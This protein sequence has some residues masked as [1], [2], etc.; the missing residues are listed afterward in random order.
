MAVVLA[1]QYALGLVARSTAVRKATEIAGTSVDVANARVSLTDGQVW[2]SGISIADPQRQHESL[3][4][5]DSCALELSAAALLHKQMVVERGRVSGLRFGKSAT[6]AQKLCDDSTAQCNSTVAR[7]FDN[8]TVDAARARMANIRNPFDENTIQQLES[9]TRTAALCSKFADELA[10]L[11]KRTAEFERRALEFE[12]AIET[13]RANSLRHDKILDET[14]ARVTVLRRELLDL[15]V[16]VK[17]LP[18]WLDEER[19]AIVAARKQDE[20]WLRSR[21]ESNTIEPHLLNTYLLHEHAALAIDELMAWLRCARLIVPA[22]ST[23]PAQNMLF[24]GAMRS[25]DLLIHRI[26][27]QGD[28]CIFGRQFGLSGHVKGFTTMR[29]S[30]GEPVQ[31]QLSANGA[32]FMEIRAVFDRTKQQPRDE[33][34]VDCRDVTLP[35]QSLGHADQ[36]KLQLAPSAGSISVSVCA[37]GDQLDGIIQLVQKN[38]QITSKFGDDSH[39]LAVDDTLGQI[40][41]IATRLALTGTID[42][43]ACTLW[44]NLGPAVALSLDHALQ[45]HG[46]ER[47]R[48][49]LGQARRKVDEQLTQLDRLLADRQATLSATLA[50]MPQRIDSI[51][52]HQTQR[53]RISVEHIG[54]RLPSSSILR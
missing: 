46:D 50:N 39:P 36:L 14:P 4:T 21:L 20:Q 37:D 35:A 32:P 51:G 45:R 3:L 48:F 16:K 17:E 44:S 26:D 10:S 8:S 34:F 53:E 47:A 54:G 6:D 49:L 23:R 7:Y 18:V 38:V 2:L 11:Q 33:L 13:A 30:A 5:A 42:E 9:V 31:L 28:A 41:S 25:P 40:N 12:K 24:A 15:E 29:A 43:P 52:R 1:A 27:I 19:R 22:E